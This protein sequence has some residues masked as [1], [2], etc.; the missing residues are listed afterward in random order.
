MHPLPLRGRGGARPRIACGHTCPGL[1]D[2]VHHKGSEAR[3][4]GETW[5]TPRNTQIQPKLDTP[6]HASGK[7]LEA[8]LEGLGGPR[9][10]RN[11]FSW[12]RGERAP[13]AYNIKQKC[14]LGTSAVYSILFGSIFIFVCC[15][16][17]WLLPCLTD[18]VRAAINR[19][20]RPRLRL[21]G[22]FLG[23]KFQWLGATRAS[24]PFVLL[25]S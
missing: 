3:G 20:H 17:H 11:R 21:G 14:F 16:I 7:R 23:L 25:R 2:K 18:V 9:R 12:F 8:P 5:G 15:V 1:I 19:Y 24:N 10:F 4:R 6:G 13:N 22:P